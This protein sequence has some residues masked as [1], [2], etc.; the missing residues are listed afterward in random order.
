M[1]AFQTVRVAA[2][3]YAFMVRRH[4]LADIAK[5]RE[6]GDDFFANQR[7]LT[8]GGKFLVRQS[9]VFEQHRVRHADLADIMEE[10]THAH[11]FHLALVQPRRLRKADGVIRHAVGMTSGVNV[12]GIDQET[13]RLNGLHVAPIEPVVRRKELLVLT[14]KVFVQGGV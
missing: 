1:F 11:P 8:H 6:L 13:Q 10:R 14:Q 4:K 9:S 3:V 5:E 7:M 12:L 2:P